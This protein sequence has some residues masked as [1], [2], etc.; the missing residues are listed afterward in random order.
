[1]RLMILRP[2]T[3]CISDN[4]AFVR[5]DVFRRKWLLPPLVRISLPEPVKRKRFDVALWVLSFNL[6]LAFALRGIRYIFFQKFAIKT[7]DKFRPRT[8]NIF[9]TYT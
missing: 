3:S 5:F 4:C 7:A 1:M 8:F 9:G 2:F 6:P